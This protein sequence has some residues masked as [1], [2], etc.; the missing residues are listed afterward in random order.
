M[1]MTFVLTAVVLA[2]LARPVAAADPV[3]DGAGQTG[4]DF[5]VTFELL[6]ATDDFDDGVTQT[7]HKPVIQPKMAASWGLFYASV[8]G[9]NVDYGTP[10]PDATL[11][12]VA[13]LTPSW[14][15]WSFDISLTREVYVDEPAYDDTYVFGTATYDF[16][17][18]FSADIG[19][20]Y[21]WYDAAADFH[22]IY[23]A[24]DYAFENGTAVHLEAT[25]DFDIDDEGNGYLQVQAG[26]TLPLPQGFEAAGTLGWEHYDGE[27]GTPSY[28][29]WE[30]GLSYA[31]NDWSRLAV[32]WHG[33]DLS[34]GECPGIT[35]TD[36][37]Q[38]V[39]ASLTVS[40]SVSDLAG[41]GD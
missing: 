7:D 23:A 5:D 21:Y 10:D 35:D 40:R 20:G 41:T 14:G 36:C 8:W 4:P 32:T 6:V 15:D 17:R 27:S 18:G 26:A 38:R 37:D 30:I 22:E 11:E 34:D 29:W 3:M 16:G 39:V 24:V 28:L 1:R 9:S 13:G 31:L 33:N 12:F 19:Y 2:S 25:R